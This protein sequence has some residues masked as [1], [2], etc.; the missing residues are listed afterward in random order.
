MKKIISLS[1]I[2]LMLVCITTNV[3]AATS[4]N[5]SLQTSKSEYNKGDEFTVDVNV[6]DLQ[7]DRGIISFGATLEYDINCLTFVKMEGKNGWSTPSYNKDSGILVSDGSSLMKDDGV[8]F[9]ITFKVNEGANK[10]S[11]TI[12]LKDITVGDGGNS[13]ATKVNAVSKNINIKNVTSDG[14]T[15]TPDTDNNTTNPGTNPGSNNSS[16]SSGSN[17]S[18]NSNKNSTSS[19]SSTNKV[20]TSASK[21][22][23]L[24]KAGKTGVMLVVFIVTLT[25]VA[26]FFYVKMRI[27]N[28]KSDE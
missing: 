9:T 18:S 8:V 3:Y 11:A 19:G 16:T 1:L 4:C 12:S 23:K 25:G 15:T 13:G 2:L 5:A 14:N 26:I 6:T 10:S 28:K 21:T 22:G 20:N 24:P 17:S 27:V 7:S